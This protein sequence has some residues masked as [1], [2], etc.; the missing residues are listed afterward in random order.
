MSQDVLGRLDAKPEVLLTVANLAEPNPASTALH[1]ACGYTPAGTL[2][3]VGVKFGE[4]RDVTLWQRSSGL[5]TRRH[6]GF[7]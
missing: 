6:N 4:P 2:F 7:D 1:R 5:V 3:S